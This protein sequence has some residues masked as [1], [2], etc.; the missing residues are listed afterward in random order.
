MVSWPHEEGNERGGGARPCTTNASQDRR[1]A[2]RRSMTTA[3]DLGLVCAPAIRKA[4]S[5][6]PAAGVA[7]LVIVT[8][9]V[10]AY[11]GG[12]PGH[13]GFISELASGLGIGAFAMLGLLLMLPT[14]LAVFKALG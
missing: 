12:W 1:L 9:F 10:L 7:A 5:R 4:Y 6:L 3:P 14:R 13:R 2:G 8:P 11:L